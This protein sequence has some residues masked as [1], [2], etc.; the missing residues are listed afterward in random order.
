[1]TMVCIRLRRATGARPFLQGAVSALTITVIMDRFKQI[2]F[3]E[4]GPERA[5]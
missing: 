3:A 4:I 1:M 5:A 2:F